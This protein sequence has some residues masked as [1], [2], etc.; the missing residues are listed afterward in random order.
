LENEDDDDDVA[1]GVSDRE[2]PVLIAETSISS[3]DLNSSCTKLTHAKGKDCNF[4]FAACAE[5]NIECIL[6]I[7][8]LCY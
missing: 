6:L 7:N 5:L 4:L 3:S 1:I 2:I 8:L